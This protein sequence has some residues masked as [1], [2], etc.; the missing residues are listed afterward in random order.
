MTANPLKGYA[1]QSDRPIPPKGDSDEQKA[2]RIRFWIARG[3]DLLFQ[4]GKFDLEWSWRNGS[5][6][7]EEKQHRPR[8]GGS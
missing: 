6:S 7:I 5:Y 2:E 3:N 8:I 1:E 4:A